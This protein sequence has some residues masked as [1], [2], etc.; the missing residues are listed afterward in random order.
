[1]RRVRRTKLE[2]STVLWDVRL[3]GWEPS[4]PNTA[5]VITFDWETGENRCEPFRITF[6][7]RDAEI[8]RASPELRQ[9]TIEG[10]FAAEPV[11][12]RRGDPAPEPEDL[13]GPG[14]RFGWTM[15]VRAIEPFQAD[16]PDRSI[17]R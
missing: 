17:A 2:R 15:T 5:K 8:L 10:V 13:I 3:L 1:M 11:I 7:E 12:L 4:D 6:S 9:W 16:N 14:V